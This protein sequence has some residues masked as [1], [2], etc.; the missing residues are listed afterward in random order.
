M[1]DPLAHDA[2]VFSKGEM[3][4]DLVGRNGIKNRQLVNL[5]TQERG[6]SGSLRN[7]RLART[8]SDAKDYSI[9]VVRW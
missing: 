4:S 7:C 6:S 9:F 8:V 2:S 1:L 5:A 3:G